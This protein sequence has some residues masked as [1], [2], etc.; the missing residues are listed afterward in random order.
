L[1]FSHNVLIANS[2]SQFF[3]I[4]N[5]KASGDNICY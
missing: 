3:L 2:R 4:K 1:K 5:D